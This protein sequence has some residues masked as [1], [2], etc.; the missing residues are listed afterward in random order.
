[1]T[2]LRTLLSIVIVLSI[3]LGLLGYTLPRRSFPQV[4]GQ[5][6]V[7]GLEAP[8][9]VYRDSYG[10]PQIYAAST[11]DLFF[12][13]GYIHA[14]DRFWQM[15]LWRHIGSARLS[16]MFG[17][18]Q[19]NRDKFLRTLGWARVAQQ[20]LDALPPAELAILQAYADGV[21]AYLAAHQG[22]AVS[23]EYA[24]LKFL[25]P[26]YQPEPW[27][28][29]HTLTWGKA[30]A[31]TLGNSRLE[32]EIEHA[33]LLGTLTAA[34]IDELFPAYPSD[35]PL[36]LPEFSPTANPPP[37]AGWPAA[38][39]ALPALA[40]AFRALSGRLDLLQDVLG[41]A[42]AALAQQLGHR[43]HTHRHPVCRYWPTTC[44]WAS[45]CPPSGTRSACTAN[46]LALAAF[47]VTGFPLPASPA[48]SS[49]TP[50]ASP[51]L[52]QRRPRCAR[53][54]HRKDQPRQ[55]ESIRSQ[56]PVGGYDPG[57]RNHPGQRRR[58]G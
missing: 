4:S 6:Q 46:R 58:P 52:H 38:G 3:L 21:N 10:I 50:T 5:I 30:M 53:P 33:I 32:S 31:W 7:P 29:I 55:P 26:A 13:Q 17:E 42:A 11:H 19:L 37:A 45:K 20:E 40:P 39:E 23:L 49:A 28:P 1:M 57:S 27:Q 24:I 14:Q 15:D 12:A 54:V 48:S 36:V 47:Q 9:D 18:G 43:R 56:R 34:Q 8:V 2:V 51:G 22:A 41:P 25:S 16:E 35:Q 44:T